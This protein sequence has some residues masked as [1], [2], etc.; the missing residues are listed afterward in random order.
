LRTTAPPTR[1]PAT[2]ATAPEP[3]ATNTT[4]RFPWNARPVDTTRPT[5]FLLVAG[6]LRPTAGCAPWRGA[7]PRWR[8]RPAC[9]CGVGS[10]GASRA[11]D[12]SADTFVWT[13]RSASEQPAVPGACP[14]ERSGASGRDAEVYRLGARRPGRASAGRA[15][16]QRRVV[17][18]SASQPRKCVKRGRATSGV[19]KLGAIVRRA[20]PR[21]PFSPP[22]R[23]GP[24]PRISTLGERC[25]G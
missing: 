4:T 25:C 19:E 1:R 20:P 23:A 16:E 6:V 8:V 15:L 21:A 24:S 18:R 9:A 12:C 11:V 2:N 7:G 22:G 5:S 10:R 3:G 17:R 14:R 13:S